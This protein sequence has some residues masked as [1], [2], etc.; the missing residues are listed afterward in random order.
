MVL[1]ALKDTV[2]PDLVLNL[3][4]A[5]FV[6]V[7]MAL[8]RTFSLAMPICYHRVARLKISVGLEIYSPAP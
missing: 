1:S 8:N 5:G 6:T 2:S 4:V 7:L 3:T